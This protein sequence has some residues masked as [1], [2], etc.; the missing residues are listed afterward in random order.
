MFDAAGAELRVEDLRS[1]SLQIVDD[2]LPEMKDVVAT[3]SVALFDHDDTATEKG[4]LDGT[5][6]ATGT[7]KSHIALI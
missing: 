6:K 3:E 4:T 7:W 5:A 1:E 2:K